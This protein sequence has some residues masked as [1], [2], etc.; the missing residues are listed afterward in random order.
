VTCHLIQDYFSIYC[1]QLLNLSSR[2]VWHDSPLSSIP[3]TAQSKP[4]K[5]HTPSSERD[6]NFVRT[7]SGSLPFSYSCYSSRLSAGTT[8]NLDDKILLSEISGFRRDVAEVVTFLGC[9]L[10]VA[11][12]HF[13]TCRSHLQTAWPLKKGPTCCPTG[14]LT[15][16]LPACKVV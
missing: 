4:P 3:K 10:L 15:N 14:S 2:P 16:Y 9:R 8:I 5:E 13:G 6:N 12:R 7:V 11:Y 1:P